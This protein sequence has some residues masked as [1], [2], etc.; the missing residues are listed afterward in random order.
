[1]HCS[2]NGVFVLV[3]YFRPIQKYLEDLSPFFQVDYLL[4]RTLLSIMSSEHIDE[5]YKSMVVPPDA[6]LANAFYF[7]KTGYFYVERTV[8]IACFLN[9]ERYQPSVFTSC[10]TTDDN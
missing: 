7:V 6:C 5:V 2:E 9:V 3:T 10:I 4:P 8:F 1:M